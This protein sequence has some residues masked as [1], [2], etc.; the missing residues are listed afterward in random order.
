MDL[1]QIWAIGGVLLIVLELFTPSMLFLNFALACFITA[2]EAIYTDN[3]YI[4]LGSWSIMSALFIIFLRPLLLKK[5][6]N[7]NNAT[8]IDKYIG[9]K[10]KAL[11]NITQNSGVISIFDER[12]NARSTSAETISAGSVVIIEHFEDLTMYVKKGEIK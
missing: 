9:K 1:W 3:M 7:K 11:E 10:A 8:G 6:T 4:L 5:N 2:I 12:W